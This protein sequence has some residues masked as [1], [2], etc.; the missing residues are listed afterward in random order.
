MFGLVLL[1]FLVVPIVEL[2][3]IVQVAGSVG[4]LETIGLLI[5]VSVVGA[6]LVRREGI[7]VI[8]RVQ[9][10][11]ASGAMPNNELVDG[12]LILFAGALML[13]PGFVTD[14]VGLLLLLPPTRLPIRLMLVRRFRGRVQTFGFS[15]PGPGQ[16][17]RSRGRVV[18]VDEVDPTE[19][20]PT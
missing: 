2:Y 7:G 17:G 15:G 9:L 5:L 14:A 12:G 10:Q 3:V 6:W 19:G 4:T 1:A 18:D 16:P 8:R 13:T 20:G 11:L